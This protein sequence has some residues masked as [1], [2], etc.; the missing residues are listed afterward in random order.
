MEKQSRQKNPHKHNDIHYK[1]IIQHKTTNTQWTLFIDIALYL[2]AWS[3]KR[4][5]REKKTDN[6]NNIHKH[7]FERVTCIVFSLLFYAW[8]ML[9]NRLLG[10][11]RSWMKNIDN[12]EPKSSFNSVSFLML[13]PQIGYDV[14]EKVLLLPEWLSTI[15][16]CVSVSILLQ[17]YE[18]KDRFSIG[19]YCIGATS[20]QVTHQQSI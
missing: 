13:Q 18:K 7:T 14:I 2:L 8:V 16:L 9:C 19:S 20:F 11:E 5:R 17:K 12:V 10:I 15:E 6:N 4:E 3:A 1:I